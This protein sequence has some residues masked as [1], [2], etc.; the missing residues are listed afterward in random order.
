MSEIDKKPEASVDVAGVP[1]S[2]SRP[3]GSPSRR[4][5]IRLGASAVPVLATLTSQSALAGACISTSA[6]GSDQVS[7][8]ASQAAR[9][10]GHAVAVTNGWTI[11]AWNSTAQGSG[12][13]WAA[14]KSTFGNSPNPNALTFAGLYAKVGATYMRSPTNLGYNPSA[15]VMGSLT[16]DDKGYFLVAMLNYAVGAKPPTDCVTDAN[17]QAIVAGTYPLANPWDL[18][19]IALYLQNNFI[20][21][22]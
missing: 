9:H 19:Q 11:S 4:R 18:H 22:A 3:E 14:F 17:W 12:T 7:Q 16:N 21:Q 1:V 6:W 15:L 8:S 13:A 2:D 20:V 5:I 10:A